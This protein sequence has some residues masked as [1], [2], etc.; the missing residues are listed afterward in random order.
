[1][2]LGD[3]RWPGSGGG[4][5]ELRRCPMKVTTP[6]SLTAWAHL[7]ARGRRQPNR[8]SGATVKSDKRSR[9]RVDW[10]GQGGRRW[11]AAGLENKGGGRAEIKK[12]NF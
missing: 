3:A 8:T 12:K 10:A 9:R 1:M 5:G 2:E 6:G 11:A 7:S 4:M